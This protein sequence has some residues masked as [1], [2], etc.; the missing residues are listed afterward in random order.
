VRRNG[1]LAST[2]T[3]SSE[4]IIHHEGHEV[5]GGNDIMKNPVVF[6]DPFSNLRVLRALRG[7]IVLSICAQ[8]NLREL[9]KV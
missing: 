3:Q 5:H 8:E 9:R 6:L 4:W 7:E 2:K 1:D